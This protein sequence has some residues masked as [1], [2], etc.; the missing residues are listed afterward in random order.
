MPLTVSYSAQASDT[1][2]Y[3]WQY[4]SG[5][6][7]SWQNLPAGA[8]GQ[9]TFSSVGTYQMQVT[10]TG[11]GGSTTSSPISI[12]V[13]PPVPVITSA[14]ASPTSGVVP[15]T[16]QLSG[17]ATNNPTYQW[18]QLMPD[19][20]WA[21]IATGAT[22]SYTIPAGTPTGTISIRLVVSNQY[23]SDTSA[24]I[25]ISVG[26]PPVITITSPAD[27][28][29]YLKNASIP[30]E[31]TITGEYTSL[32]W[33]FGEDSIAGSTTTNPTTVTY[34]EFGTK[35]V[36]LTASNQYGTTTESVTFTISARELRPVVSATV[37][38]VNDSGFYNFIQQMAPDGGGMPNIEGMLMQAVKPYT[39][40]IGAFF[41]VILF[42]VPYLI[43]WLKQKN[44]IVPSIIGILFGAWMLVKVPAAYT[45]PAVALLALIVA[46][47]L[48]G[49]YAK[50]P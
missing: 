29:G 31:A 46:G 20:V 26:S 28:G 42:G 22:A 30:A 27:G 18:Q 7:G 50:Q 37:E 4:R 8:S 13:D 9:Y 17:S 2:T 3:Q 40:Q 47:G 10:A 24:T 14:T 33:N 6:S 1:E 23:G 25:P 15:F 39:D 12:T 41:Y 38:P 21:V 19:G 45:M 36:T 48:Y 49:L 32:L 44:L 34:T 5:T 16:I 35:T 43:L 11:I